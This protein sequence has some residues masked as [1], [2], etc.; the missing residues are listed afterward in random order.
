MTLRRV[1]GEDDLISAYR[2]KISKEMGSKTFTASEASM[3]SAV[4][5]MEATIEALDGQLQASGGPWA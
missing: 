5:E 3:R 4:S 1:Q 2:A